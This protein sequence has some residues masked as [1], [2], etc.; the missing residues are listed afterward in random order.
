[1]FKKR[2]LSRTNIRIDERQLKRYY[3]RNGYLFAEVEATAG[4]Y[5]KDSLKAVVIFDISEGKQVWIDSLKCGGGLQ[6]FNAKIKKIFEKIKLGEP[7]NYESILAAGFRIRDYYAD[8]GYPFVRITPVYKFN[9]DSSRVIVHFDVAENSFVYNGEI[10][11][12]QEGKTKTNEYI[13]RR[14][15]LTKPGKP[16]SR[17]HIIESQQ[18]LYSTGLIKYVN[19]KMSGEPTFISTD[20]AETDL[21][22]VVSAR[23]SNFVNFRI[24]VAQD[25]DYDQ[26]VFQQSLSWGNR[27]LWGS[28]RKLIMSIRNSFQINKKGD[29]VATSVTVGDLFSDL[30]LEPV[31][32]EIEANFIQPWFLGYRMPLSLGAVYE[33]NSMN[34]IIDKHYDRLSGEVSLSKEINRFT[35]AVFSAEIEFID[36]HDI[37][38]EEQELDRL[39]G[40]RRLSLYGQRDTR[41]NIFIPQKG[42]YSYSSLEYVG[43]YLGGD[44]NYVKGEFYWSRYRILFGDNILASR[45]RIG[46][47]KELG[48]YGRSSPDDRFTLGGAKTIRGVAEND[49]GPKWTVE[50]STDLEGLPKGGKLLVL[51]NL[52]LRSA[53]FWR[54]GGSVFVDAGNVF[55]NFKDF[56]INDIVGTTGLGLHFFTPVGPLRFE[57]AFEVQ[58]KL[59]LGDGSWHLTILYA[60]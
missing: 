58:K 36:F 21:R 1:M 32:L 48:K 31:K 55:Y 28:G 57:Y 33:P 15:L 29:T 19:L 4:L 9:S 54:I 34:F 18:R 40:R 44:F 41:D 6:R 53:L 11:I 45:F 17:K 24:G 52:E 10:V 20:T 49:L 47:L 25:E 43:H 60:F 5:E 51:G 16:Y 12:V 2:R 50:E 7:I 26:S 35:S 37:S 13:F 3:E 56:H 23:K 42:S 38:S 22:L 46:A 14:E 59:D 8:N 30:E 27:N 39:Q